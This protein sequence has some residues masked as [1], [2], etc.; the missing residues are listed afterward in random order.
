[1]ITINRVSDHAVEKYQKY[2]KEIY[3]KDIINPDDARCKII[4][5][6]SKATS[7]FSPGLII[8]IIDNEFID[9]EYFSKF[10]HNIFLFEYF[11]W[12]EFY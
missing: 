4:K 10:H 5:L 11:V 6:F 1:M 8:R 2:M 3:E 12:R 7:E 9:A